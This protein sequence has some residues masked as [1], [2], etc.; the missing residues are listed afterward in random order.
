MNALLVRHLGA[1]GE[2]KERATLTTSPAR[3][4]QQ[5]RLDAILSGT[6]FARP[7]VAAAHPAM[8][9]VTTR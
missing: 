7:G 5:A 4:E 9:Q 8:Q 3:R 6:E 2:E 1:G